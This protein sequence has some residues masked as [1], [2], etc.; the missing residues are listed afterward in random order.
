MMIGMNRV[1]VGLEGVDQ[2]DIQPILPDAR[3]AARVHTVL[4]PGAVG[5]EHEVV[6]AQRHLVAVHHRER[7]LAFHDEAM[8]N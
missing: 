4:V 2:R 3:R 6:R 8:A 7:A 5:R 1:E